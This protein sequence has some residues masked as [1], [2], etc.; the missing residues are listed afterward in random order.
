MSA[1]LGA[2][3]IEEEVAQRK[4]V[5]ASKTIIDTV[6]AA[7]SSE[8]RKNLLELMMAGI[9]NQKFTEEQDRLLAELAKACDREDS[10]DFEGAVT[11]GDFDLWYVTEEIEIALKELRQGCSD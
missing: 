5:E 4:M 8:S 3:K 7:H 11:I 2:V 6:L 1:L 10:W 9:E